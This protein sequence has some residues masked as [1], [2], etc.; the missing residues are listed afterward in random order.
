MI[1]NL[2]SLSISLSCMESCSG[3]FRQG[4]QCR[5]CGM[6]FHRVCRALDTVPPCPNEPPSTD[7]SKPKSDNLSLETLNYTHLP[8][9]LIPYKGIYF[10]VGLEDQ[11]RR[12]VFFC[13][14]YSVIMKDQVR[15]KFTYTVS[16]PNG[17]FGCPLT[18]NSFLS[19]VVKHLS[20]T[21]LLRVPVPHKVIRPVSTFV[22]TDVSIH[23]LVCLVTPL[24]PLTS[25]TIGVLLTITN[26][27]RIR[28]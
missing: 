13:L 27:F 4:F 18:F 19:N 17:F 15:Y 11:V 6:I 16:Q 23:I 1:F 5:K 7:E 3:V 20:Y 8:R 22:L 21:T 25:Q 28:Q 24:E 14:H 26:D 9:R 10:E 12:V 2:S